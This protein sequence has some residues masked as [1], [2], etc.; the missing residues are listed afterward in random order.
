MPR[1]ITLTKVKVNGWAVDIDNKRVTVAFSLL[2]DS[3][4]SWE[5]HD[6]IFWR[7]I[8]SGDVSPEYFLLPLVGFNQLQSITQDIR[9]ALAARYLV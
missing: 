5:T 7:T 2:D 6:A 4:R 1:T 3:D 9:N 8:P